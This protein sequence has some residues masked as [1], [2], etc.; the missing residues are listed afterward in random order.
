MDTP[1][2][3]SELEYVGAAVTETDLHVHFSKVR[4]VCTYPKPGESL[5]WAV[6]IASWEHATPIFCNPI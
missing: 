3:L 4:F 2:D 1:T 5:H 6:L